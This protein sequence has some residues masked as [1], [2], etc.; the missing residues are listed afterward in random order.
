MK[1]SAG[2]NDRVFDERRIFRYNR[3]R[4]QGVVTEAVLK[5][6]FS[7]VIGMTGIVSL[8]KLLPHH[9]IQQGKLKEL[10]AQV[11]ETEIRVFKLRTELNRNFDPQQTQSLLEEY[12]ALTTPDRIHVFVQDTSNAPISDSKIVSNLQKD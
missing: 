6:F 8:I 9:N 12:S 2:K 11:K 10:R 1:L 5:L 3:D 7:I 4:N